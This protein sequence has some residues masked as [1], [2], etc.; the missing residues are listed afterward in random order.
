MNKSIALALA[1]SAVSVAAFADTSVNFANGSSVGTPLVLGSDGVAIHDAKYVAQLFISS[2]NGASFSA[3]GT[4]SPFKS[5]TATSPRAGIWASQSIT[6][7]GLNPS[8]DYK[9]EV[10]VWDSSLFSSWADASA[11]AASL[12]TIAGKLAPGDTFQSGLTA[13]FN[14]HSPAAG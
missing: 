12:A 13:S 6:L 3:V 10:A 8:T 7:T 14:Y 5:V 1:F 2:D 4:T 11:E 9:V